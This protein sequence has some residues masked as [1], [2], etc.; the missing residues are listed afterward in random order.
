MSFFKE[1]KRPICPSFS[2]QGP[3]GIRGDKGEPG[4]KGPRGLPGLKGHNGLQGLPGL[5]VSKCGH[6]AFILWILESFS[7]E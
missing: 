2:S 7:S 4:D 3:H 1:G 6:P 5:A